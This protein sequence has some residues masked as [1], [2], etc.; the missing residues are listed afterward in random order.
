[1]ID[2]VKPL[3]SDAQRTAAAILQAAERVLR[4]DP[5]ASL[6]QIAA[7]AGV[8][9]TTVHRRFASRQVLIAA[10]QASAIEH[11][12]DAFEA[13]SP[14]TAPP[15]VALHRLTVNVMRTKSNWGYALGILSKD[16]P[17]VITKRRTVLARL[18]V[19]FERAQHDGLIAPD[20]NLDW[21][22]RMYRA[23]VDEAVKDLE[24]AVSPQGV[25]DTRANEAELDRLATLILRTL[26]SGIG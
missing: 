26:L 3:R 15:P 12:Y 25:A 4:H 1:M 14:E 7:A 9:R 5:T 13:A 10:L 16:D 19:L 24:P 20:V 6:E 18:E 17:A 2:T 21:A 11:F 22:Q 8:T 23:M